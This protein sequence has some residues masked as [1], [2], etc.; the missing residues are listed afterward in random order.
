[1]LNELIGTQMEKLKW[2]D[3]KQKFKPLN[4]L[5]SSMSK[6][7]N[8]SLTDIFT[9]QLLQISS[10]SVDRAAAIVSCYPTPKCLIDAFDEYEDQDSKWKVLSQVECGASGRKIGLATCSLIQSVYSPN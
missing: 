9:K 4:E 5:N 10:V 2:S 3:I 8:L 6:T 1:M 7:R